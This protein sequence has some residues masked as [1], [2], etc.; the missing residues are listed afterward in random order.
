MLVP[1]IVSLGLLIH[2]TTDAPEC[3][4]KDLKDTDVGT[5]LLHS[6][7]GLTHSCYLRN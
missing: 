1:K 4:H 2:H 5:P 7:M 6:I 3:L